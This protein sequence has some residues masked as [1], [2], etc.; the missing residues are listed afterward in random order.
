M[1]ERTAETVEQA[2][3]DELAR[4]DELA[5]AARPVLR[6]LLIHPDR[7]LFGEERVS[8][9]R[10]MLQDIAG[11][12]LFAEAEAAGARDITGYVGARQDALAEALSQDSALLVHAQALTIEAE[13]A[14]RLQQRAGV[15]SVLPPLVQELAAAGEA[16]GAGL[17]MAVL[18]AQARFLQYNRRMALPL[19]ELPGDL[20]HTVLLIFR[21]R[22]CEATATAEERLRG[23][24]REGMGRLSLMTRLVMGLGDAAPRA[25]AI[26]LAGPA[27]FVTALALASGQDRDAVVMAL[28]ERGSARLTLGLRAA[29]LGQQATAEQIVR[30]DP[31][32][33][34]PEGFELI[35]SGQAAELL[36]A[37]QQVAA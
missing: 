22:D 29:G 9:I 31:Q 1:T 37:A 6:H 21:S 23:D 13:L 5:A 14:E 12:L 15:D 26:E 4:G 3:R 27:I 20:F 16:T 2:L 28:G 34:P 30:L 11:Q 7:G 33:T 19:G 10:G 25:L 32:A 36:A 24:Y 18:A 17:A 35:D 8:R